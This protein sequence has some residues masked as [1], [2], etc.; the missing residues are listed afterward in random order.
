M[1]ALGPDDL[2]LIPDDSWRSPRT[3]FTYPAGWRLRLPGREVD[4]RLTVP[5]A[6][7]E[8]DTRSSTGTVYWEGP[9]EATGLRAG[10][11]VKGFGYG[12]LVGYDR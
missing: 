3:G 1:I 2:S 12:E 10:R 9:I 7:C 4:L 8:L 5:V 6:D 11:G